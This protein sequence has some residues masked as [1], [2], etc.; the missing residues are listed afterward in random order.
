MSDATHVKGRRAAAEY[1]RQLLLKP[2]HYRE[3]WQQHVAR[4]RDGVINQMAV[5]E[6]IAG[7]L[8]AAP[9]H[10]GDAQMMPYQL[11][12]MVSGALSGLQLSAYMV[13][14]FID[15]FGFSEHEAIRLWRLWHGSARIGVLSGSHA[16]TGQTQRELAEV[17]G[18]PGHQTLSLHDHI[19]VGEDG[20]IDRA[21]MLH[22]IEAISQG[23]DRI[24]FLCDTNVLTVEVGQ[25]GKELNGNVQ[26]IR[27]DM[28]FAEILLA[29][30][31]DL[32]ETITL[33]YWV[34]YRFPG[35]PADPAEREYRRAV[36][37]HADNI[38]LRVEFHPSRRPAQVWWAHWDGDDGDVI[39]RE[40]VTL[41]SQCSA[42]RYVRSVDK[43][44]VGFCWQWESGPQS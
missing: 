24:P 28:F 3:A 44:V 21:R 34:T 16:V 31:L 15:A 2:G 36:M 11:R 20:R 18:P 8:R 39:Q 12:D 33:E 29:R 1:L 19:Y 43:T 27:D 23:V 40:T 5:A 42:Q 41:D 7:R 22:V 14:L 30:T 35:D 4:P 32:G 25:G 9:G 26:Q 37:R 38:D 17:L 10:P 6:V 13:E